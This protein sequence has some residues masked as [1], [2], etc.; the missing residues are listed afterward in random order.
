MGMQLR[1]VERPPSTHKSLSP[2]RRRGV[3]KGVWSQACFPWASRAAG[4]I[5]SS[6]SS[7]EAQLSYS[8]AVF[9]RSS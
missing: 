6:P 5:N 3:G 4:A 2:K 7:T 1:I 8:G 9:E